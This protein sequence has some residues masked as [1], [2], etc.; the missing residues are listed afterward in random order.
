MGKK[1]IDYD[2]ALKFWLKYL[3]ADMIGRHKMIEELVRNKQF[4]ELLKIEKKDYR[5]RFFAT[6]LNGYFEDLAMMC[7]QRTFEEWQK[8]DK[9]MASELALDLRDAN[10]EIKKQENF[11]K[12][13]QKVMD[14]VQS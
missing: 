8:K 4:D 3:D 9:K 14:D 2:P 12:R 5:V 10:N 11:I 13:I 1:K 6:L 7:E